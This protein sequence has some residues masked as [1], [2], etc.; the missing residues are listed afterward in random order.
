MSGVAV[1]FR[2]DSG[3]GV[4]SSGAAVSNSNGV[5]IG[6]TW[7]LGAIEGPQVVIATVG[8]LTPVRIRATARV[9]AVTLPSLPLSGGGGTVVVS[10]PGLPLDG[11]RVVAA[12]GAFGTA[13]GVEVAVRSSSD[14]ALPTGVAARSHAF[15]LTT[16][17]GTQ[18]GPVLVTIPTSIATTTP[19]FAVAYDDVTR[20]VTLLPPVRRT[21]SA[22]TVA[23]PAASALRMSSITPT[24]SIGAPLISAR[25]SR[26]MGA[27]RSPTIVMVGIDST[28]LAPD[29]DTGFRP[30]TD[31]WVFSD[32]LTV[33]G[34]RGP[35]GVA[36]R[37]AV[38]D[39]TPSMTS[40]WYFLNQR[41]GGPLAQR[42]QLASDVLFSARMGFRWNGWLE[43]RVP[44]FFRAF[45]VDWEQFVAGEDTPAQ[46][47]RDQFLGLKGLML[48]SRNA[49]QAVQV[50]DT[51]SDKDSTTATIGIAWR[52]EGNSVD[53]AIPTAAERTVRLTYGPGGWQQATVRYGRQRRLMRI[54]GIAAPRRWWRI[55]GWVDGADLAAGCRRDIR[56]CRCVAARE[57]DEQ[58]RRARHRRRRAPRHTATLVG[59]R[60]VRAYTVDAERRA[61][62]SPGPQ[63]RRRRVPEREWH[64]RYDHSVEHGSRI[65]AD[66]RAVSMDLPRRHVRQC[67]N[68]RTRAA[69]DVPQHRPH[70][71]DG[72]DGAG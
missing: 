21:A 41:S 43:L 51:E 37:M 72:D 4:L 63:T 50:Y 53:V 71:R 58:V 15:S 14:I 54:T 65:A 45:G 46:M 5:A 1:A 6:G 35:Q 20:A 55:P 44:E 29:F 19:L 11:L 66:R 12:P 3:G 47:A 61:A 38:L 64:M 10:R 24:G 23:L 8:A 25:A 2:V 69:S 31:A 33:Y 70:D 39:K 28:L 34:A 9:I 48:L 52:T 59:V 30:Q 67:G 62:A 17:G 49:P 26:A 36:S 22:L 27:E 57:V 56:R 40:I 68:N 7:Q 42:F 13:T 32:G 16:N 60:V 18:A